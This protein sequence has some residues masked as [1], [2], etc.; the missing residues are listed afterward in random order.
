MK[1]IFFVWQGGEG[2][3]F[4]MSILARFFD[5]NYNILPMFEDGRAV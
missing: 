4:I 3:D 5:K 2:G 1:D